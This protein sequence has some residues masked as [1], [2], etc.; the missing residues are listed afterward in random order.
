MKFK[1]MQVLKKVSES[2]HV[3]YYSQGRGE[4]QEQLTKETIIGETISTSKIL[5]GILRDGRLR[6]FL[7]SG[8][9]FVMHS[10]SEASIHNGFPQTP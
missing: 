8:S 1:V 6:C 10:K 3:L 9:C 7:N 5:E 2:N 4:G